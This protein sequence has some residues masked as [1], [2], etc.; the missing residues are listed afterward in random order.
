MRRPA[1]REISLP[2]LF[3]L[4]SYLEPTSSNVTIPAHGAHLPRRRKC[5]IHFPL[6]HRGE[7]CVVA[8]I[9][10]LKKEWAMIKGAPFSFAIVCALAI[11]FCFGGFRFVYREKFSE[12]EKRAERWKSDADY[13]KDV[14]NR[15]KDEKPLSNSPPLTPAKRHEK[16]IPTQNAPGG[17]NIGRDNIGTAIVNNGPPP[18][19]LTVSNETETENPDGSHTT[20]CILQVEAETAPGHLILQINTEGLLKVGLMPH[21]EGNAGG[22]ALALYNVQQGDSFYSATINGPSG[23]YDLSVTR[24]PKSKINLR[25]SFK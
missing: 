9:Q 24:S 17:I 23:R 4:A 10:T 15:P 12:S 20:M 2:L 21:T 5:A 1:Q 25:A 22:A 6:S 3:A 13:W 14:A 7:L 18:P 11:G 16:L 8:I 19:K